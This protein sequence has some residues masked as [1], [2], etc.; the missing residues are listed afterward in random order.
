MDRHGLS[1][2]ADVAATDAAV[3][4][5]AAGY[6]LCRVDADGETDSLRRQNCCGVYSN[7]SSGGIHKRAAGIAGVE[8][9]ISLD[10]IVDQASRI[11]P[12]RTANAL[13]TP[14]VT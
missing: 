10:D 3:A 9:G 12:Q 7:H 5:Q 14:A 1:R 11:R 13:T 6:E 8:R 2:N 4:Q